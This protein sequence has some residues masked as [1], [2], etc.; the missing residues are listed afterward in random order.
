ME[1]IRQLERAKNDMQVEQAFMMDKFR[2][3]KAENDRLKEEMSTFKGRLGNATEDYADILEHRQE[4]I[5]AEET[6]LRTMQQ[7]IERMEADITRYLEDIAK[8]SE[9]NR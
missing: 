3:M 8:L 2:Q 5:K 9:Q 7:Q 4:Q 6:K 1:E